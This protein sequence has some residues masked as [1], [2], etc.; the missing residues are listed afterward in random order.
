MSDRRDF[1]KFLA[2]SPLLLAYPSL[3]EALTQAPTAQAVATLANAADA[4]DVFG[5]VKSTLMRKRLR[6]AGE[7]DFDGKC[8]RAGR[9]AQ[10]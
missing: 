2:G 5:V 8:R 10:R 9:A 3:L 6:F 4:L 1:L 7:F